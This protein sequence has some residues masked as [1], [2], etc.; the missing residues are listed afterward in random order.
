MNNAQTK[1]NGNEKPEPVIRTRTTLIWQAGSIKLDLWAGAI[2]RRFSGRMQLLRLWFAPG[3]SPRRGMRWLLEF[4]EEEEDHRRK[5]PRWA[6]GLPGL[7]ICHGPL[8]KPI[9]RSLAAYIGT[10]P[11]P[12]RSH[13]AFGTWGIGMDFRWNWQRTMK[14]RR[15]WGAFFV[16]PLCL[17]SVAITWIWTESGIEQEVW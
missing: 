4:H 1:Q 17:S 2:W 6:R 9:L 10:S 5:R 15:F 16:R 7:I 8:L 14:T 13:P 12:V 3:F 11:S